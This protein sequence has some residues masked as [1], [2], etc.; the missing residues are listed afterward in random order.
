[1]ANEETRLVPARYIGTNRVHRNVLQGPGYDGLGQRRT[2]LTIE[3]GD[4][5]MMP[6]REILGQTYLFDPRN[7]DP[8]LD[9][10]AGKRVKPEHATLEAEEL[11]ILGYQFHEGRPDFE[12]VVPEPVPVDDV[13]AKATKKQQG[14]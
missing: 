3:Q 1:V 4:V 7:V 2:T 12:L 11:E 13:P 10:G 14:G 6:E 8:P 5:L 9:L